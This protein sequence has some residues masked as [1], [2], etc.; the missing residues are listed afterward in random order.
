[1]DK[2]I[3]DPRLTQ[4]RPGR[5]T[6]MAVPAAVALILAATLV[7]YGLWTTLGPSSS[8]AVREVV[9]AA[10]LEE[11]YGIQVRLIGVTAAGGLVDFRLKIIDAE[12]ARQFVG[13]PDLTLSL[14]V[15]ESDTRLLVP[16][17]TD[18]DLRLE[19]NGVFLA[20]VPNSGGAIEPGTA[21]VVAFGDLQLEPMV[22]Q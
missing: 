2:S 8:K 17:A 3:I 20:L 22:A 5:L 1:M 11:R 18:Q 6:R 19:D 4:A 21:V 7:A 9:S 16:L 10:E 13:N 12:K 14:I 15:E